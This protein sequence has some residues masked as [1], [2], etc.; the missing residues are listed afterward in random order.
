[1]TPL[2][3]WSQAGRASAL[4]QVHD[5]PQ[6]GT[7]CYLCTTQPAAPSC[8]WFSGPGCRPGAPPESAHRALQCLESRGVFL[9]YIILDGRDSKRQKLDSAVLHPSTSQ[10]IGTDSS[11][12]PGVPRLILKSFL[13]LSRAQTTTLWYSNS[14]CP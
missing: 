10:P 8:C 4:V 7:T 3:Q 1:M 9:S 2:A 13:I 12:N 14:V 11:R 5:Q 6:P